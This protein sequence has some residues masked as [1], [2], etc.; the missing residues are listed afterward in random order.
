MI[1]AIGEPCC[2]KRQMHIYAI[3][4]YNLHKVCIRLYHVCILHILMHVRIL[5]FIYR[6]Y[7]FTIFLFKEIW[8]CFWRTSPLMFFKTYVAFDFTRAY[9]CKR[10][11]HEKK[12]KK[13]QCWRAYKN[14]LWR[15]Y[16]STNPVGD[17][18]WLRESSLSLLGLPIDAHIHLGTLSKTLKKETTTERGRTERFSR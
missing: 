7:T 16:N 10:W 5:I 14:N 18:I 12:K 6:A 1:I 9:A 11:L 13:V 17:M 2:S 4:Y 8:K 3:L 15:F